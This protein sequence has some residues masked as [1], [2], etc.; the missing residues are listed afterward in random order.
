MDCKL[1]AA[2][3][4]SVQAQIM[5]AA[6]V[7]VEEMVAAVQAEEVKL[8]GLERAVLAGL[9]E[10]G[11]SI[12][13][14]LC[15][16][17]AP[18]YAAGQVACGCGGE[19]VYQRRRCGQCK[20]LLGVIRVSRP[21]YLCGSCRHG[22]CPLDGEL[23]FCAGSVS[24][25]LEALLAQLGA[26]FSFGRT[27]ALVEQLSL[28]QVSAN[29]CRKA[30][31][32]LGETLAAWEEE[33][34]QA[35]WEHAM[36]PPS[37][38]AALAVD[39]LYISADGVIVQ[40]RETGGREQCVGAVY[41]ARAHGVHGA[42]SVSADESRQETTPAIRTEAATFVSEL[43]SRPH[44]AQLLWLEAQRRGLEQAATVVF[45]GDGA[46]WLWDAAADL[47]PQAVQ[48]L[49]WYH[50]TTYI[51]QA[52]QALYPTQ[53]QERTQWADAQ[54]DALWHS[55]TAEVIA[56]LAPLAAG[57]AAVHAALSYFTANQSR[58]DYQRYRTHRLQVGSG[59]IES[60]CKHL[61]QARLKQAGMRWS[62]RNARSLGKLRA[63]L[64]S[65]R[66]D[67]TLALRP[68][69]AR[70]YHRRSP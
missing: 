4:G 68:P 63:R 61:I 64:R 40:T 21:Y 47:F 6:A 25:G 51:W 49:D 19:A 36:E 5:T 27:A 38:A 20:T 43:G 56:R 26:E 17:R 67:E 23:G 30:T 59:T 12:L 28:V 48:I 18:V 50:A 7:L 11:N 58:M 16:V 60:A 31:L 24:S 52:A 35:V 13:A 69:P 66:W 1:S 41:T 29:R 8:E 37:A 53:A 22:F 32:A 39:P 65:G 55:R 9:H 2:Q 34:R 3:V 46:H 10:L 15:G 42:P 45:I 57:C 33:Q 70:A 54:L 14:V 62:L 44:F